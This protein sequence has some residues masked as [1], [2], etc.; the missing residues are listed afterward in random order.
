M[1]T[2]GFLALVLALGLATSALAEPVQLTSPLEN[3]VTVQGSAVV[4]KTGQTLLV[5]LPSQDGYGR[6]FRIEASQGGTSL[7]G[8]FR[9]DSAE[10]LYWMGHL[11]LMAEGSAWHFAVPGLDKLISHEA[12][13]PDGA[14]LA[15]LTR[16][17]DLKEIEVSAIYSANG[18]RA[19]RLNEGLRRIFANEDDHQDPGSGGIGT[20]GKT[21]T[22][23]CGD[24]SSCSASCGGTRCAHCT[25]PASC[26]CS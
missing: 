6:W 16:G 22:I 9:A 7:P 23:S 25:C 21:C 4:R 14:E 3:L 8:S 20:C 11:V 15:Q 19:N 1:R 12:Q 24:G 26:S 18:P 2:N 10:V 5:T 13:V 17:Y